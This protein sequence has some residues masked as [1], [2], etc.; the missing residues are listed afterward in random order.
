MFC[1]KCGSKSG[2]LVLGKP[3]KLEC[4]MCGEFIKNVTKES[5]EEQTETGG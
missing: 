1:P 3:F 4:V 2:V 5:L